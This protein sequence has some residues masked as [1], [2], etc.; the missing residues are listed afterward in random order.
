M[1]GPTRGLAAVALLCS[2]LLTAGLVGLGEP[3]VWD[4]LRHFASASQGVDSWRPMNQARA[5]LD[6]D[7]EKP[8]YAWLFFE[9]RVK[10]IYPPP[11]LL[12]LDPMPAGSL[13]QAL[14][15]FSW[16]LVALTVLFTLLVLDR[17]L[18][19]S[20]FAAADGRERALRVAL[21][22]LLALSFYPLLKAYSLGQMQVWVNALFAAA[23][24]C[25]QADRR[26]GAGVLLALM[27]AVKPQYALI[28]VWG[29][30]RGERRFVAGALG[31]GLVLLVVSVARFGWE[32]HV[33]YLSVV[34]HVGRHGEAYWPNQT[35]GGFLH[36]L[37]GNGVSSHW[38]PEVYPPYHPVVYFGSIA[39]SLAVL[40][41]AFLWPLRDD[42][43]GSLLDFCTAALAATLASPIAW[44]HHYG[45][46]LP[47]FAAALPAVTA[48]G[49]RRPWAVVGWVAAWA[50][51]A[52]YLDV[53]RRI[54]G[55]AWNPLQSLLL[56]A[57]L[58][59]LA[60]LVALRTAAS[61]RHS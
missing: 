5:Y 45:V 40:G 58:G 9:Q 54:D 12:L 16:V 46:L 7:A 48:A 6:Q 4:E 24:W 57:A 51:A 13:R 14:N 36:R 26:A 11:S 47:I 34:A 21:G 61:V 43:R 60:G 41:V 22:L 29:L 23:V 3:S 31:A 10:F 28:G 2:V 19:R 18:Q 56:F 1:S 30:L 20:R 44:E 37:L 39:A 42:A 35:V 53:L 8:L 15:V 33:D 49:A 17:G 52:H 38:D 59:V 32:S 25:W 27:A 50:V 55:T